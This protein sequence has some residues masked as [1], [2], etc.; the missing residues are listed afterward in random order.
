MDRLLVVMIGHGTAG[1]GE[2]QGLSRDTGQQTWS[3]SFGGRS[4]GEADPVLWKESLFLTDDFGEIVNGLIR[5]RRANG[6]MLHAQWSQPAPAFTP[7]VQGD[8]VWGQI[9]S[10]TGCIKPVPA[11]NPEERKN[12]DGEYESQGQPKSMNGDKTVVMITTKNGVILGT[13]QNKVV[14]FRGKAAAPAWT[15]RPPGVKRIDALVY[16]GTMLYVA[17]DQGLLAYGD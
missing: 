16:D 17:T 1:G 14:C 5:L 4:F 10:V 12:G 6:T 3:H 7:A 11:A 9:A 13:K 2:V 15:L 8:R